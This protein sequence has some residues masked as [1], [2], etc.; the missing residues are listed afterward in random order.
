MNSA[1]L[2]IHI[3]FVGIWLGCVLTE[4]LFERAL[5]GQGRAQE[6]ILVSLHKRVDLF[7]EIPA[8]LVVLVTGALM[9]VNAAPSALLHA[10]IAFGFI[11]IAANAY[12]V[13]LVFRRAKA[14]QS[15]QWQV[16]SH[17]DHLQHK[18]GAI[19]LLGIL[20]ALG[21]GVYLH[22]HA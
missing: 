19:V 20:S 5:L 2:S 21:I 22:A 11:A 14:A 13:W 18:I 4:A 12:C 3:A 16:F 8:F 7:V 15:G 10:K 17:L 6:L 9:L 1:L